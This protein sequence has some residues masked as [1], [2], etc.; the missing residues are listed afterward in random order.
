MTHLDLSFVRDQF[1]AFA[2]PSL[3]GQVHCENAGG[4]YAC[5]QVIERLNRYYRQ[6]KVQ[7]YHPFAAAITA[8]EEMDSAYPRLAAYLGVDAEA[9]HLGPSTSQNTAMLAQAFAADLQAGDEV[10]VTNQDHEANNGVW[11]RMAERH[12]CRVREWQVDPDTGQ[13]SLDDFVALV[14]DKTKL[15]AVCHCSNI[16]GEINPIQDVCRIAR[17]AGAWSV[18]DGV[19]LAPHGM[20]NVADLGADA[21]L[22]SLYKVF[23][24]HQGVMVLRQAL[25][26]YLGNQG[27]FF[28]EHATHKRFVPAG[29]DHAQVA[30]SNG[31]CDYFD[32]LDTH[33]F[34]D[35]TPHERPARVRALCNAAEQ[36]R[37][38]PLLDYLHHRDDI[39]L[40]GPAQNRVPTVSFVSRRHDPLSLARALATHG[41][42][43]GAGHF[44]AYRLIRALGESTD[45]GAL[46]L[47]LVH[48]TSAA[49]VEQVL[50][51]LDTVL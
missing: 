8:G 38:A 23:G 7:P 11:R 39:R 27:H 26:T 22:F 41:V 12:Q 47:S 24:P 31:V 32:A 49:E 33:H 6:R 48:Y 25:D 42:M 50:Q 35:A 40:L 13:L 21:Y 43:S 51:A 44:Y 29:P 19:S 36:A 46:R 4:S 2:E 34:P 15:V 17:E 3:Q 1:P 16:V 20:P 45:T 18:I 14:N 9:V 10:I 37:L 5:V 28:N 30:A